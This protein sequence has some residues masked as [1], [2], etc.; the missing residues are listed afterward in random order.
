MFLHS[1]HSLS[2]PSLITYPLYSPS[3]N[4]PFITSSINPL[5]SHTP[6]NTPPPH[7]SPSPP[8][9]PPFPPPPHSSPSLSPPLTPPLFAPPPPT[10]SGRVTR[11]RAR[12]RFHRPHE[13]R[14]HRSPHLRPQ[15]WGLPLHHRKRSSYCHGPQSYLDA[16]PNTHLRPLPCAFAGW[17]YCSG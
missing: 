10:P 8:P 16:H 15:S 5:L 2:T 17:L 12:R 7:S 13:I 6:S 3:H 4:T 9:P 14:G 1:K 11:S